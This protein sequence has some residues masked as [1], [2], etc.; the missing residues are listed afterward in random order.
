MAAY[1]TSVFLNVPFDR[2][3]KKL[4]NALVFGVHDCGLLSRCALEADDGG[5]VRLDKLYT[6]IKECRFGIHDLSRTTLDGIHRLP[7]F[8]MPLELGV[9]LGAREYGRGE[10]KRKSLLI[11]DRAPYRYQVFCSDIAGQDIRAHDND[12]ERALTAIR[13]WLQAAVSVEY[14][15]SPAKLRRRYLEFRRQ[16]PFM[17]EEEDLTPSE[18]TFLDYRWLV[19]AWVEVN[20]R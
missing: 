6:I 8:N 4:L 15:P 7:R 9:F 19:D 18:L 2:P 10:Q 16:L 17:C 20:P 13:N 12:A 1:E 3:Y 14:L 5:Q 11:L